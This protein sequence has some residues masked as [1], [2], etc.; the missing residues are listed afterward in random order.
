MP[1]KAS[2]SSNSKTSSSST[3]KKRTRTSY[4][5]EFAQEIGAMGGRAKAANN[6]SQSSK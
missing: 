3:G 4:D 2:T 6:K 1:K 5:H